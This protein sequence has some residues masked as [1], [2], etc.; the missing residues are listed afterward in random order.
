MSTARA[1]AQ[2][3]AIQISGKAVSTLLGLAA[4]AMMTRYLGVEKFGWYITAIGFLQFVGIFSDFGFIVSTAKML[5][6][7][8][9]D[10][11]K[12][13]N[14]I[15][16]WRLA[17][18][19]FFNGLA[20]AVIW[21]FPYPTAIKQATLILA[22]SFIA[23]TLSHAFIGFYQTKMKMAVV[24]VGEILGRV[25][26]VGCIA[27][28]II[29]KYNFIPMMWAVTFGA[30]IYVLYLWK[31]S[32]GVRLAID[33]KISRAI[34]RVMWPTAI[35]IIFNA[36]YLQGDRVLLPLY[37]PA[38]DVAFYGAAY[39]VLDITA[40]IAF[41]TMGVMLPLLT[42]TWSRGLKDEFRKYFQ[43]SFDLM[44]LVLVPMV[45]GTYV[46]AEPIMRIVAGND[47]AG[48]GRVLALLSLS[49]LGVC[50]GMTFGQM[51][52][53]IDKQHHAVWVYI[54]NAILCVIA[55]FIFIPRYGMYGAAYVTIG[56]EFYAGLALFLFCAY[57]TRLWP[58]FGT[59]LKIII[60]GLM[61][62][63]T[64][65]AVQPLNIIY[66]IL[67]GA[68]VYGGLVLMFQIISPQTIKEILHSKK[69]AVV[70]SAQI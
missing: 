12:L 25:V 26:L 69:S 13:F 1:I 22:L 30:W 38:A 58:R 39:R 33:K 52:L 65:N 46:L 60:A 4:I 64:V 40:Q 35:G 62:A 59:A 6:E 18:T 41:F 24:M 36:F 47:F 67:L 49:S 68:G 54:S 63:L 19:I 48:A 15:F 8:A 28:T 9:F 3:T 14:N 16:T 56:S 5:S 27:L 55:Y 32:D 66:S 10:K 61:M 57:H 44:L 29:G 50:F 34:L 23:N 7:P 45:A 20:V 17:T 21:L 42:Y 11:Q 31:N 2:N 37:A 53:A 51:A 43:L 70:E